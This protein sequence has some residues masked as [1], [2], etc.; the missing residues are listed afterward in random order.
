MKGLMNRGEQP[1]ISVETM[2][3]EKTLSDRQDRVDDA[4]IGHMFEHSA[5]NQLE[6]LNRQEKIKRASIVCQFVSLFMHRLVKSYQTQYPPLSRLLLKEYEQ[7]LLRD[8]IRAAS[9]ARTPLGRCSVIDAVQ[10]LAL[11]DG[12][13]PYLAGFYRSPLPH[14]RKLGRQVPRARWRE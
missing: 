14:Q 11:V 3:T 6:Y 2:G 10:T 1:A 13:N 9:K 8:V 5:D 4:G 12:S 7:Q